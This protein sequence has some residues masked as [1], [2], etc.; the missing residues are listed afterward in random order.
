M[1]PKSARVCVG[2]KKRGSVARLRGKAKDARTGDD[3][4]G[5]TK[6]SSSSQLHM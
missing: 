6:D 4:L 5:S 1:M 2:R 3:A